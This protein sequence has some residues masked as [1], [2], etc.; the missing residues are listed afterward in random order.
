M[1][2]DPLNKCKKKKGIDPHLTPYA[3]INSECIADLNVSIKTIKLLENLCDLGRG[4]LFLG[5]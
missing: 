2:L 1:V 4:K 3:E 5:Y